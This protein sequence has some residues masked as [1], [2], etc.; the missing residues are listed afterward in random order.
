MMPMTTLETLRQ[1]VADTMRLFMSGD[2]HNEEA[3]LEPTT[4]PMDHE[5]NAA[6]CVTS[7][8]ANGGDENQCN[9]RRKTLPVRK[10]STRVA[11][12][13]LP[14]CLRNL[15]NPYL[16]DYKNTKIGSF[17]AANIMVMNLQKLQPKAEVAAMISRGAVLLLHE[18]LLLKPSILEDV[19]ENGGLASLTAAAFWILAKFGGVRMV[20]PD[21]CLVSMTAGIQKKHLFAAEMLIMDA[22]R[23]DIVAALKR[24]DHVD[25]LIL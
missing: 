17:M 20:T 7:E 24:H 9:K 14:E 6:S 10:N 25:A 15:E 2:E 8:S 4:P 13:C 12:K 5:T 23:W 18:A 22:I 19:E 21:A 11:E 16:D 3:D 1:S